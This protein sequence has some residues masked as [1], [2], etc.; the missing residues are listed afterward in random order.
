MKFK[1]KLFGKE[2]AFG[3]EPTETELARRRAESEAKAQKR[4]NRKPSAFSKFIANL[5]A[6]TVNVLICLGIGLVVG[7]VFGCAFH[8]LVDKTE[9][10]FASLF[11]ILGLVGGTGLSWL[12]RNG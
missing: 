12:C 1:G 4:R 7:A 11:A 6:G 10:I 9:F 3:R 8:F 2:F 5:G